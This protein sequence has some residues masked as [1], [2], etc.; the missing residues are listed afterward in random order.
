MNP[1][2]AEQYSVSPAPMMRHL[3]VVRLSLL[4]LLLANY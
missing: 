4:R 3:G 2:L 1:L